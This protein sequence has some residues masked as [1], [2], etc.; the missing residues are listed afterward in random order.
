VRVIDACGCTTIE[1]DAM[2]DRSAHPQRAQRGWLARSRRGSGQKECTIKIFGS[3]L[4][5]GASGRARA[6][7]ITSFSQFSKGRNNDRAP[8]SH[9]GIMGYI[10]N[11]LLNQSIAGSEPHRE[12]KKQLGLDLQLIQ[13]K[14]YSAPS[15]RAVGFFMISRP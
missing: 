7:G 14:A 1:H 13:P 2:S 11:L 9:V 8:L 3:F 6:R 10:G 5:R 12:V 4:G 15:P